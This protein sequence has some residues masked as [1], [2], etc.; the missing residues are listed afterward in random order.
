[1]ST[2]DEDDAPR[3]SRAPGASLARSIRWTLALVT[4]AAIAIA[5]SVSESAW[6]QPSVTTQRIETKPRL[7]AAAITSAG[8]RLRCWQFGRLII[9][10][11][12]TELPADPGAGLPRVRAQGPGGSPV[13]VYDTRNATCVVRRA[14]DETFMP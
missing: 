9:D 1:M 2:H 7:D 14:R 10:E 4:P 5:L 8:L 12:I 11:P 6:P 13:V 3:A